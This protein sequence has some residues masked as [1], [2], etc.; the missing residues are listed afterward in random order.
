VE[1][2][3]AQRAAEIATAT[4]V[5]KRSAAMSAAARLKEAETDERARTLLEH[6]YTKQALLAAAAKATD[7]TLTELLDGTITPLVNEITAQ[8][9]RLFTDRGTIDMNSQG[10]LSRLVNGEIL[11]FGS[12]STGEKMGAQILLRLLVLDTATRATFCWVDEPLEHLDPDTRRQVALRLALTP[13]MSG[14]TQILVTTYEEPL[15]RHIAQRMPER[16]QV[17]YVRTSSQ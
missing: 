7:A 17:L 6:E 8:W 4:L 13:A 15:V 14:A 10:E 16:V 11:E 3:R 5:E 2:G 1:H 9:K 12:F